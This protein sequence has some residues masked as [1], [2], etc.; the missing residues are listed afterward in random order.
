LRR[1][2]CPWTEF[3][4]AQAMAACPSTRCAPIRLSAAC[5]SSMP[6]V[7][8]HCASST[9]PGSHSFFEP[10]TPAADGPLPFENHLRISGD[11]IAA[12][13]PAPSRKPV[14][15]APSGASAP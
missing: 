1:F 12:P 9:L 5:A 7:T 11:P 10:R 6:T 3:L 8:P 15:D 4:H 2:P 14:A 13:G